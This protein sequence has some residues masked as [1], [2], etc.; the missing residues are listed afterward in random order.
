MFFKK[1]DVEFINKVEKVL[2]TNDEQ[3]FHQGL[4]ELNSIIQHK[5]T[6]TEN[7]RLVLYDILSRLQN[8]LPGKDRKVLIKKLLKKL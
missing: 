5:K 3:I 2:S 4:Y 8:S 6:I 7:Q 1:R